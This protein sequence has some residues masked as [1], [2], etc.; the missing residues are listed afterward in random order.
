MAHAAESTHKP[1]TYSP[2]SIPLASSPLVPPFTFSYPGTDDTISVS[3]DSGSPYQTS[4]MDPPPP[5][6]SHAVMPTSP[7]YGG[8]PNGTTAM[9]PSH[10]L[11][12][13]RYHESA[14]S[15]R[16]ECGNSERTATSLLL[17]MTMPSSDHTS[18]TPQRLALRLWQLPT[19]AAATVQRTPVP[20]S[21]TQQNSAT[22]RLP[23]PL[24]TAI[25]AP[26]PPSEQ[27]PAPGVR[28]HTLLCQ[29]SAPVPDPIASATSHPPTPMP[30]TPTDPEMTASLVPRNPATHSCLLPL[31]PSVSLPTPRPA[32]HSL[33]CHT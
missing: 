27:Q 1:P 30:A 3:V 9:R 10:P 8:S 21:T 32:P 6:M 17:T 23:T 31:L 19:T 18:S 15:R 4:R 26:P 14:P 12:V 25:T 13:K 28:R 33:P 11:L 2:S 20:H 22:S 24:T 7:D 16:Q 29:P 5:P